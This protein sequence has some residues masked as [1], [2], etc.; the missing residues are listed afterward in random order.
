MDIALLD[1]PFRLVSHSFVT[2]NASPLSELGRQY[3]HAD[4][5]ILQDAL[6]RAQ[7]LEEVAVEMAELERGTGSNHSGVPLNE[8]TLAE[9]CPGFYSESYFWAINDGFTLTR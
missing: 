9:R 4:P 7:R 2:T 8:Q 1:A 3:S 5:Q 6:A